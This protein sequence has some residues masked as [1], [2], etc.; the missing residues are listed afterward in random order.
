MGDFNT[1][2]S[3]KDREFKQLQRE[4]TELTDIVDQMA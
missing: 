2:L 1:A 3:P 4:I